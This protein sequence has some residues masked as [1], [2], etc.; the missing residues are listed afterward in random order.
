MSLV[1]IF[2]PNLIVKD[3]QLLESREHIS[4][5]ALST[6]NENVSSSTENPIR[7][8][9]DQLGQP[10]LSKGISVQSG[11]NSVKVEISTEFT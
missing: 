1:L 5:R 3:L 6:T 4:A 10:N 11:T 8:I 7:Q 9:T 2:S